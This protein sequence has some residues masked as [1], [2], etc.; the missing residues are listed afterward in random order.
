MPDKDNPGYDSNAADW[1]WQELDDQR[2]ILKDGCVQSCVDCHAQ[3]AVTR[4]TDYTCS[5]P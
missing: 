4:Q 2:T 5:S 1:H 3:C